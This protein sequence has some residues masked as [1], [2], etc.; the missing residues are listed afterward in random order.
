ML[1][2]LSGRSLRS[3]RPTVMPQSRRISDIAPPSSVRL[4]PGLTPP[5]KPQ[6]SLQTT[7]TKA[8]AGVD[9]V[10]AQPYAQP[11]RPKTQRSQV[12]SRQAAYSQQKLVAAEV[13]EPQPTK[14]Q[15]KLSRLSFSGYGKQQLLFTSMAVIVFL[16]GIFVSVDTMFTNHDAKVQVEALS[17]KSTAAVA[18]N[19]GGGTTTDDAVVPSETAP[20]PSTVAR[21]SVAPDAPKLITIAKLGVKARVLEVGVTSTNALGTPASIY[22]TAWYKQSAKPGAGAGAGATLI[23]GHVHGPTLPGVFVAIKKLAAGDV[24]QITRG[25]NQVFS[26]QVVSTEQVPADKV[27]VG[28]LLASVKPGVA[29]LNLI[30]CGGHFNYK[31]QHYDDRT[32]VHAVLQS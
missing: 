18:S 27:D 4:R 6:P 26:Y 30:T 3:R 12:L 31:T 28:A 7:L 24:I 5:T 14:R 2:D 32:I 20:H 8:T 13:F 19:S 22:D 15:R 21:Y 1:S 23:D 29:G 9:V 25:D 11:A 16:I 17:K 10:P